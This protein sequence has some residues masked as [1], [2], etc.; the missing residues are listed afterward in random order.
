[1]SIQLPDFALSTTP[2]I[3]G[4]E[5][6]SLPGWRARARLVTVLV[7]LLAM[8]GA[9]AVRAQDRRAAPEPGSGWEARAGVVA[10]RHLVVA[11]NPYAAAAGRDMLRA[12][13]SAVDAAIAAQLVLGLV[14]P[15]SSGLGGGSFLLHWHSA[16]R[17]LTSFDGRETAPA[18]ARPDRFLING[19][20]MPFDAAV[21]SGLSVGTPGTVR[22]LALAH[23][24]H[25][26]LPWAQLFEP[27]A[28]LAEEGFL[29]SPRLRSLLL[30]EGAAGFAPDARRYFFDAEG[31]PWPVGHRLK[32]PEF[33]ATLRRIAR[34]GERA[35]Y[36]GPIALA[37]STAVIA[38]PG[39]RGDLNLADLAGY[40]AKERT[41]VCVPYRGHRVC[42]MGPPSSGGIAVGQVLSLLQ[43]LPMEQGRAA[44]MT[45][46]AIH[47]VAEATKLA[48]ADRN[49]YV[50]DPDF[51][52]LPTGLLD[53][54]YMAERR[55]LIDPK[56]PMAKSYPGLPPGLPKLTWGGDATIEAAGTTHVSIIDGAGNAVAM[57][58]TIESGFGSRLW[59]AGFLLNNELTDFSFRP[60]GSE[61]RAVANRVQP[62][63]RPR[64]SMAPTIVLNERD[65]PVIVTGS[66][67]GSRI[68]AYVL[69]SLVALIDWKLDAQTAVDLPN[70]GSRGN[71]LEFEAPTAAA[72]SFGGITTRAEQWHRM[73]HHAIG[74][75]PFGQ[76]VSFAPMTSG[77]HIIVR[78]PD[79]MLEGGV[80]PRREGAALGD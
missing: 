49:W 32:N 30:D 16:S 50:A 22:V 60:T 58:S 76:N 42:G 79:G 9:G 52:P 1:M 65:E 7:V 8:L 47:L 2:T 36:E 29:L 31:Q 39:A 45:P 71:D 69:K 40:R 68:I 37:I 20:P 48:F 4:G 27:A 54:A 64:S 57:T 41:P 59:A 74:M 66:P 44:A 61:G 24:R 56:A 43:D 35:F 13:G 63:K 46:A 38:A 73:L 62:G 21:R 28:R 51:V 72:D 70:F 23:Q 26:K 19:R 34:E 6:A 80:D 12:G 25:G 14:E 67:G 3:A 77:L 18:A 10:K 33:A 55:K 11:A 75:K 15:Q 5:R 17:S 53:A 78:R